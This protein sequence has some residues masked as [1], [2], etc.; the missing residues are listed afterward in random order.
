MHSD[1]ADAV[2]PADRDPRVPL[3]AERTLLAWLRT[4][5]AMTGFGFVIARLD[6]L[7]GRMAGD[8]LGRAAGDARLSLW[9]GLTLVVLGAAVNV[10]AAVQHARFIARF[11]RGQP[12]RAR[13]VSAGVI[14]AGLLTVLGLG[15]VAYLYSTAHR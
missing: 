15:L 14:V 5:L 10:I 13:A 8:P 12:P 4:G 6:L 9:A 3:A 11:N 1:P 7:D 2:D